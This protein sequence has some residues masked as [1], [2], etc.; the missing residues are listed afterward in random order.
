LKGLILD[1]LQRMII[2]RSCERLAKLYTHRIDNFD[3]DGVLDLWADDGLWSVNGV[4]FV[5]SAD[6]RGHAEIRAGLEDRDKTMLCRH[7]VTN[8]VVNAL[9]ENEADGYCYTLNYRVG[10]V[11]DNPP[12]PLGTPQFLVDYRDVFTRHPS[13]GWLFKTRHVTSI[14]AASQ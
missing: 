13:R 11:R 5:K 12:G 7:L 9:S 4:W 6:M 10:G 3:Y 8:M 1:D 14:L 2:E